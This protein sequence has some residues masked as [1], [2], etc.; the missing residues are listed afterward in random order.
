[1]QDIML[2]ITS[3]TAI[4]LA[5]LHLALT[6]RVITIR[7]KDGVVLGD[8][9]DRVLTKA[10]RGQAN[11]AEQ[12]PLGLILLGLSELQGGPFMLLCVL[13]LVFTAGRTMHAVYFGVPGTPWPLRFYGMFLTLVG[14]AGLVCTLGFTVLT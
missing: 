13:A 10:I 1:M 3:L 2:P 4:F 7:R 14:H 9:D 5:C 6:W 12:I 8:N 11:A